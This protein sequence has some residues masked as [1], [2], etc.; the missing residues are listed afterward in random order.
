M[1]DENAPHGYR[2]F[3]VLHGETNKYPFSYSPMPT[4]KSVYSHLLFTNDTDPFLWEKNNTFV[5]YPVYSFFNTEDTF[6]VVYMYKDMSVD[7]MFHT[8][9]DVYKPTFVTFKLDS[10]NFKHGDSNITSEHLTFNK[11]S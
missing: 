4:S 7:R 8:G 5:T 6:T 2:T 1:P 9:A 11:I 10:L 3:T